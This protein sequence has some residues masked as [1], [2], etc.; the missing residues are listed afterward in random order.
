MSEKCCPRCGLEL[1]KIAEAS[2][3]AYHCKRCSIKVNTTPSSEPSANRAL[4][5]FTHTSNSKVHAIPHSPKAKKIPLRAVL[6]LITLLLIA[7]IS[8]AFML[9]TYRKTKAT[10]A[11][12]QTLSLPQKK[13]TI[14]EA[15][16]FALKYL[17]HNTPKE[18]LPDT[19]PDAMISGTMQL[20]WAPLRTSDNDLKYIAT[21]SLEGGFESFYFRQLFD[22]DCS[23]FK[24]SGEK[25]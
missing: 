11:I 19:L 6:A 14:A 7:T 23:S 9:N 2:P 12:E 5:T 21:Y 24:Q 15:E 13:A 22:D 4:G 18:A 3:F 1:I 10:G 17:H 8:V 25:A 20:F 16:R